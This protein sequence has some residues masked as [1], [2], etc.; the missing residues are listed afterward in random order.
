MSTLAVEGLVVQFGAVRSLD[1]L[2]VRLAADVQ[3]LIGPNGAGKTT[4][5]NVLSGFVRPAA[6]EVLLD[7]ETLAGVSPARR[8]RNGLRRTFQTERL[9]EELTAF[10][11]VMVAA[12]A[13]ESRRRRRTEVDDVCALVG[14]RANGLPA[15]SLDGLDRKLTELA[16][17]LVGRPR[18]V[19]LDEPAGGLTETEVSRLG[20]VLRAIR[21]RGD[22]T[23]VLVDHH[24][25]LIAAVCDDVAVIDRGRLLACGPTTAVLHEPRVREAW[26]G[27]TK[28]PL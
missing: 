16:R 12:D 11:N 5:L 24:V 15:R 26:L 1:D 19:L 10:G 27:P 3:G 28:E 7:G 21:V 9:A 17:A 22:T 8:A 6:G 20:D 18:V 2:T 25:E 4:L 23:V 14:L 13:V